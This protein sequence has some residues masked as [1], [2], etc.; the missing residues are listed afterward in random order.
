[1]DVLVL[2]E[3]V[4]VKASMLA[5]GKILLSSA[6]PS[7]INL[8]C[9]YEKQFLKKYFIKIFLATNKINKTLLKILT[10]KQNK[11]VLIISLTVLTL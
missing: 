1:M 6:N 8:P 3:A 4:A 5:F 2:G 7:E 11:L 10:N 9:N